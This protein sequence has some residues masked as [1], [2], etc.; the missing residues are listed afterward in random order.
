MLIMVASAAVLTSTLAGSSAQEVSSAVLPGTA[1]VFNENLAFSKDGRFLR[2]VVP[3]RSGTDQFSHVRA[4]TYVTATGAIRHVWNLQPDTWFS[5][6]TSDGRTAIISVDRDRDDARARVLLVDTETGHTQDIPSNWFDADD[7]NPHA[8]ISADGR[9]V[10][11]YTESGSEDGPLVVSLY[12]WRTKK[13]VAKQATGYPAGGIPWGGVTEDGKIEFSDSRSGGD[14]VDP[15]T[16]RL[17]VSVG[18]HSHRSLDGAWV[19]E[20]PNTLF[21][22]APREVIIRN[23]RGEEVGKLDVQITEDEDM[24]KWMWARSAFCGTSGRFIAATND[25]VEAFEIPSGKKIADFPI[26]TWRDSHAVKGDY[27]VAVACSS[28]GKRVAIRS[29]ERLT[30]HDLN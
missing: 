29:G 9:L 5:S 1:D 24:E 20:F 3:I 16:G 11:A 14:I 23:G 21:G 2:E 22:D 19:V 12:D 7:H 15:K 8:Q 17:L 25:I 6:A 30:L 13:L 28:T 26:T 18:A 10:S 4:I 27:P